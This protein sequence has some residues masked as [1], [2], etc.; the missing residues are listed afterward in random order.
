MKRA[1]HKPYGL[2]CA[3]L[4]AIALGVWDHIKNS[5]DHTADNW[6]LEWLGFLPGKRESRRYIGAHVLT[7]NDILAAG[8]HFEDVVAYGGWTMDDHHPEGFEH[9]GEPTIYHPAPSPYGIPFRSLYSTDVRNLLFA[10]RNIS[11]SHAALSS[12]RVMATCA[13]MGQAV[14]NAAALCAKY[15]ILP[16]EVS[17]KHIK[18]LQNELLYDGCY[19]PGIT[20]EIPG[21][22]L[23]AA[24][25]LTEDE[26]NELF[27]GMERLMPVAT[28]GARP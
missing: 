15:D 8:K 26:K 3:M 17:E 4:L 24:S 19:L 12:T 21:C 23:N 6:A 11:A 1:F 20:R 25:N 5:G 13:V 27:S 10:E 7:E 16:A 2:L 28:A 18:E 14:G 22:T 9:Y